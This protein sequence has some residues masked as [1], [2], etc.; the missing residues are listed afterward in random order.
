MFKGITPTFTL[1]L[2]DDVDL[3]RAS[4]IYVTFA[5]KN[6]TA[7]IQK[8]NDDLEINENVVNVYLTQ[9]ETLSFPNGSVLV[10][11]NWTYIEGA[12]KKRACSQIATIF[13]NDNLERSVLE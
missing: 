7:L 5:K 11:I 8:K 1:S 10:Q 12:K 9:E 4:N 13:W 2:P 6:G 3:E